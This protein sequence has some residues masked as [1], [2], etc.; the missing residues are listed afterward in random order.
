E[1]GFAVF[2]YDS[3][4][5]HPVHT[6]LVAIRKCVLEVLATR[7]ASDPL[8]RPDFGPAQM[9][10]T[11]GATV[12]GA[13]PPLIA[14]NVNL[15]VPDVSIA[16]DIAKK[17]R[18][19]SG[20]LPCVKAI[21]V[22]LSSRG[23]AQVSMNLTNFEETPIH[24]AFEAVRREA[25]ARG[26]EVAESEIVGLVPQQA[27]IQAARFG[28]RLGQFDP[29]QVLETRL[30]QVLAREGGATAGT[31]SFRAGSA[32]GSSGGPD[33]GGLVTRFLEELSSGTPTPGGGSVAALAGALAASLGIMGCRVGPPADKSGPPEER[34]D[35]QQAARGLEPIEQ[36]LL[37]LRDQ[38]QRL[39]QTD[40]TAYDSVVQAYRLPRT[41]PARAEAVMTGLRT[42]TE[43]PLQTA[44]AAV[45]VVTLL[46][47]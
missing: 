45:E 9:H 24:V 7:M 41:D 31:G 2:L 25:A 23:L 44:T 35:P 10:P 29:S 5:T 32:H 4:A 37:A 39:I 34:T 21:G 8:W 33:L 13:R 36:R 28:L 42:A 14:F 18:F 1:L 17:V 43:V 46:K 19:S 6:N 40:A 38:L 22:D 12:V 3:A 20:G 11:A 26:V 30:E 15:A 16:K 47:S 27:L